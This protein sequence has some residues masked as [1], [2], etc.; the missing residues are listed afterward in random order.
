[1]T[2]TMIS[3]NTHIFSGETLHITEENS[4]NV[5]HLP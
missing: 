3:Q 2:D 5:Y 4:S 1:M